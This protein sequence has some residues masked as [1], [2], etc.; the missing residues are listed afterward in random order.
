MRP[1]SKELGWL[2]EQPR[3]VPQGR[4][5]WW[6]KSDGK[7]HPSNSWTAYSGEGAKDSWCSLC[8]W[9]NS[10]YKSA[11]PQWAGIP[12]ALLILGQ[13]AHFA[14]PQFASSPWKKKLRFFYGKMLGKINGS[15]VAEGLKTAGGR[16]SWKETKAMTRY[17]TQPRARLDLLKK[18]WGRHLWSAW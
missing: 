10:Q 9:G 14:V 15:R 16:H 17:W 6:L 2:P 11:Q 4:Y 3:G 18:K 12:V 13:A 1:G 7:E 5:S 8:R